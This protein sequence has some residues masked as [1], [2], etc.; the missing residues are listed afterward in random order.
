MILV[1]P[2]CGTANRVAGE[3]WQEGAVC[4]HCKT[5]LAAPAPFALTDAALPAYLA[6][7]GQPVVADFWAEWCGPCKV[8]AP[9]FATTAAQLPGVRFAKVDS[10]AAPQASA[11]YRI[12]SIP[13][14]ILFD[15]GNEV[16]RVSGAM[17]AIE[18]V[19]WINSHLPP[20]A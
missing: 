18:L 8:M 6:R 20:A 13:T 4:G 2:A 19:R 14:M 10:D 11:R 15:Q 3:R 17:S 1:C 5:A 12:R 9:Q 7:S 16:A